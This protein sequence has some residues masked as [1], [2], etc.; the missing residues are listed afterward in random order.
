MKEPLLEAGGLV[1]LKYRGVRCFGGGTEHF[2]RI[3]PNTEKRDDAIIVAITNIAG[4]PQHRS[5]RVM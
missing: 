5:H 1:T 2:C 3:S 4:N